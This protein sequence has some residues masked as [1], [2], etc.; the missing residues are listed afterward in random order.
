MGAHPLRLSVVLMSNGRR[1]GCTELDVVVPCKFSHW[2]HRR[3]SP[4]GPRT[5]ERCAEIFGCGG[6][7][8]A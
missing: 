5:F 7:M 8:R 3:S 1:E 2:S 6:A 4:M